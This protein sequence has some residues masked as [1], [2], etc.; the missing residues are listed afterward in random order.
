MAW[1]AVLTTNH[2][3][4]E[5]ALNVNSLQTVSDAVLWDSADTTIVRMGCVCHKWIG[6]EPPVMMLESVTVLV[7]ANPG[8]V[9]LTVTVRAG[10]PVFVITWSAQTTIVSTQLFRTELR[11]QEDSVTKE[12]VSNAF[13]NLTAQQ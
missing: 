13:S 12:R 3:S 5:V 10:Q 11:A 6:Q 1:H 8:T 2:V 9:M 4:L 7:C